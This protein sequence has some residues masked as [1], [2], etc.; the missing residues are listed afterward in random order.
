MFRYSAPDG[1]VRHERVLSILRARFSDRRL[2]LAYV[3]AGE[4]TRRHRLVVDG[5]VSASVDDV[6]YHSTERELPE[7]RTASDIVV[8]G[9]Q[10]VNVALRRL[11]LCLI[12]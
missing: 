8:D 10:S 11:K 1:G 7:I 4:E 12:D 5:L 9:E 2:V 3:H 6:L